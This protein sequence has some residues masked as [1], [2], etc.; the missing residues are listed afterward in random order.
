MR[1]IAVC[2]VV[3][4]LAPWAASAEELR[5][6]VTFE[7]PRLAQTPLGDVLEV[8][9]ANLR[10]RPGEPLLPRKTFSF[11]LPQGHEPSGLNIESAL[12]EV[13]SGTFDVAPAQQ[14]FPLSGRFRPRITPKNALIYAGGDPYPAGWAEVGPV[15]HKHGFKMVDV[16]VRP[17][18][19][20]PA[21][22][23]VTRL[24]AATLVL[25]TKPGGAMSRLLRA[26]PTGM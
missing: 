7:E 21:T 15:Q 17:L 6:D 22:G 11:V 2:L 26:T 9:G 13:L 12:T 8:P 3:V 16:I 18:S 23:R 1:V 10:G 25:T 14:P 4:V 24:V 19:F 5:L 20:R